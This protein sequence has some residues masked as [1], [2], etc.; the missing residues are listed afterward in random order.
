[1][2]RFFRPI[3]FE[4]GKYFYYLFKNKEFRN[5]CYYDAR[6]GHLPRYNDGKTKLNGKDFYFSDAA[7]FLSSYKEIFVEKI[8]R[9]KF[10]TDSPKILD[11]GANIGVSVCFFKTLFPN[12]S[13]LAYEADPK[14]FAYLEKNI[15]IA[16]FRNVQLKNEAVW[17]ENGMISF[18]SEGA[19][20]GM[21]DEANNRNMIKVNTVDIKDILK[22][23]QFDLVKIDIEGAESVVLPECKDYL[24]T[25][26]YI[27]IEYHS[28][29]SKKQNLSELF[30]ILESNGFRIHMHSIFKSRSPFTLVKTNNSFDMQI[31]I[32]G[33]K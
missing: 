12:S 16:G 20:G 11:I 7:S 15:D 24:N 25:V 3:Y 13:I 23:N 9:F 29:V 18:F 19:D 31:N 21:I 2:Y 32:F 4:I 1:M 14:I 10:G 30:S 27:F 28:V 22:K 5:Y 6:Y 8:Y 26:K 17:N 33:W